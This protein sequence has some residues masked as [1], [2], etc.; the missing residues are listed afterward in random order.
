M[1]ILNIGN[2]VGIFCLTGF[3]WFTYYLIMSDF[4]HIAIHNLNCK[5]NRAQERYL[6]EIIDKQ[7]AYKDSLIIVALKEQINFYKTFKK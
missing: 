6:V 7:E 3:L 5:V 2:L 4:D 1:K